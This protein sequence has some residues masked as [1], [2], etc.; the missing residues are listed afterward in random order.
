[1]EGWLLEVAAQAKGKGKGKRKADDLAGLVLFAGHEAYAP[2]IFLEQLRREGLAEVEYAVRL[3]LPGA[4]AS[5]WLHP[6][7]PHVRSRGSPPHAGGPVAT[8][9]QSIWLR[10]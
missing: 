1:V 6:C 2:L 7:S 10:C 8:Y 4:G 9:M 5:T 3:E